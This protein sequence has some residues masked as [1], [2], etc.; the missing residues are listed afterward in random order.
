MASIDDVFSNIIS[1]VR[2]LEA[3][4]RNVASYYNLCVNGG[5]EVWTA[6]AGPFTANGATLADTWL[7]SLGAGSAISVTKDTVNFASLFS[8]TCA[9]IVYTH[10][11]ESGIY[12]AVHGPFVGSPV[13]ISARIR[14]NRP[15]AVRLKVGTI[16][17]NFHS[18]SDLYET[19]ILP[20]RPTTAPFNVLVA[21]DASCTAYVDNIMCVQGSGPIDYVALTNEDNQRRIT[22]Y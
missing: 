15:G 10:G 20:V 16:Y 14:C 22:D 12:H 19:L 11:A 5:L 1:R 21:L 17:G 4:T 18:G 2:A 8:A 9:K 3:A 7:I 13:G 6:G